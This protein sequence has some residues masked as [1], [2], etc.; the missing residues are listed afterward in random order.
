MRTR[1]K[2]CGLTRKEDIEAAV[3]AGADAVGL[4]FYEPSP[5]NV[6]IETAATLATHV[7]AFVTIVGLF[8]DAD[9][10]F[11]ETVLS[12]VRIDLLQ[13]HGNEP[14]AFCEQ[15]QRP[16]IKAIRVAENT[17]IT[18][19]ATEYSSARGLLL[20]SYQKGI[21]GG[22]GETFNWSL[23]PAQLDLPVILAG[24]LNASNVVDAITTV[25]PYA[26]DVS[27]GVEQSKGI[28]DKT[29]INAFIKEVAGVDRS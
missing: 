11:V 7:P 19:A 4:V 28:K 1:V 6:S 24:G 16:Y 14:V 13:F 9:R 2:I 20:D 15:F 10:D 29:K 26:L 12:K 3:S 8:V 25:Q 27:G 22:T 18:A 5:R 23:I 17:D 21:P